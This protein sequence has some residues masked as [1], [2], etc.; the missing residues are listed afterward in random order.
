M[1]WTSLWGAVGIVGRV[2]ETR[3]S[4][5]VLKPSS[6]A[7]ARQKGRLKDRPMRFGTTLGMSPGGMWDTVVILQ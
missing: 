2:V 7:T 1:A 4:G 5:Y 6:E 3:K